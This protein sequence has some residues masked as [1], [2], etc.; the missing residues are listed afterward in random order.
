[1]ATDRKIKSDAQIDIEATQVDIGANTNVTG[2]ITA[3]GTVTATG[4]I[5]SSGD[6][7]GV[8]STL[9]GNLDAVDGDFSGNVDVTGNINGANST[10]SGNLSAVDGT[11]SGNVSVTGTINSFNFPSSDGTANQVL[12]TD[13][14]GNLG[15]VDQS[16]GGGGG[17]TTISSQSDANN[18][19]FSVGDIVVVS[20]HSQAIDF[21][22]YMSQVKIYITGSYNITFSGSMLNC[23]INGS[24]GGLIQFKDSAF[25]CDIM[26]AG[27][28]IVLGQYSSGTKFFKECRVLSDQLL[29]DTFGNG[30]V[31]VNNSLINVITL[32]TYG[33]THND[34][35]IHINDGTV[36]ECGRVLFGSSD[37]D[38]TVSRHS[39]IR[40]LNL[41]Y[42]KIYNY[43]R[44]A[45]ILNRTSTDQIE[46]PFEIV[47]NVF[48]TKVPVA[49][50]YGL[51]S[52]MTSVSS[53][54]LAVSFDD[55]I[56]ETGGLDLD[57]NGKVVIPYDGY[58]QIN[59]T[60]RIS[61]LSTTAGDAGYLFA[62]ESSLGSNSTSY[63]TALAAS[64]H[65]QLANQSS[66]NEN[67]SI[68]TTTYLAAGTTVDMNIEPITDTGC[69]IMGDG[70]HLSI[71]KIN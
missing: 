25:R 45:Y 37:P 51:T 36:I 49:A 67:S 16:S 29:F 61:G 69:V 54:G 4:D 70:T 62:I 21:P 40:V 63:P 56:N 10:L 55:T 28:S 50:R 19:S 44:S 60:V 32:D 22:N 41:F 47:D 24:G 6:V 59:A 43:N 64:S 39:T 23:V 48:T 42:G 13:G 57:S 5:T 33:G 2:N 53:S 65:N 71:H 8:N 68:S 11:F 20:G 66:T 31:S 15:F 3:T 12:K 38:I 58:Y 1:M 14:S 46:V 26:H 7:D 30:S 18:Y 35:K 27:G 17:V 52:S 34:N 9:S